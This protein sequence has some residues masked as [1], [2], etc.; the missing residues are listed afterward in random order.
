MKKTALTLA[1]IITYSFLFAQQNSGKVVY[2]RSLK[3]RLRMVTQDGN[4]TTSTDAPSF[5]TDRFELSFADEKSLY[6]PGEPDPTVNTDNDHNLQLPGM[7]DIIFHDLKAG[8]IVSKREVLDKF[9]IVD[10]QIQ[11]LDW[12]VTTENK[13]ILG[14]LCTKAE[15]VKKGKKIQMTMNNGVMDQKEIDDISNIVAWFATDIPVG[16]GP[17]EFNG[18]PGL[19]LEMDINDGNQKFLA[20]KISDKVKLNTIKEPSGGKHYTNEEF[21]KEREK[22]MA[23]MRKNNPDGNIRIIRN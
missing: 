19:I 5:K 20:T 18:L 13:T 22:L 17:S 8:K 2:D 7:N 10:D 1:L 12:K 16:A 11:K 14:H 9:F 23:E 15:A 4:S 21:K 6:E 3:L